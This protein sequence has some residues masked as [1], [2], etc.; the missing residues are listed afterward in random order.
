[1]AVPVR[2]HGV[3]TNELDVVSTDRNG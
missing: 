1:V 3:T 2:D